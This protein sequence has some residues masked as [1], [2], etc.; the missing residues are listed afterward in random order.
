MQL[1]AIFMDQVVF[2]VE[3]PHA[4]AE[5][6]PGVP[7]GAME[8]FPTP[9]YWAYQV[10]ARRLTGNRI[11]YKLGTT[12]K[13]E[14]GACLLGGHG[15]PA[16]VG[17]AAFH[18]LRERGAFGEK[19]PA[20]EVLIEWLLEPIAIDGRQVRYR[21]AKQKA[22]YLSA[23]LQKLTAEQPPLS[24]GK[25][26]R[27]WLLDIPGIGYKTASWVARNW[28]DADDVAILDIHILRAG[29]LGKF[30]GDN[31]TVERNYLELEEQFIRFSKGLGVRASELDAL[32]WLEMM[33]SPST[34][35]SIM[36]MG[37]RS[38]DSAVRGR[39]KKRKTNSDQLA[40]I[41]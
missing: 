37:H 39:T 30:F 34:V 12:L 35:H 15:I 32:M 40:L 13:E 24:S 1:G 28:L 11:K 7:W 18:H 9:A 5:V 4:E 26:L 31:L 2:N 3:L 19:P 33:S 27:D 36:G 41:G 29:L 38:S 22:R 21:F 20:E 16:N 8:A 25:E 14:V 10:Y 23:A 17:I 6:L